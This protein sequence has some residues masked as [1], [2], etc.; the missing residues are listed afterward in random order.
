MATLAAQLKDTNS[1][2][3]FARGNNYA[4]ALE[5]ALKVRGACARGPRP[6]CCFG[7]HACSCAGRC[8]IAAASSQPSRPAPALH[9]HA[10]LTRLLAALHS[11]THLA[12][13]VAPPAASA[14]R[15]R[16][17]TARASWRAR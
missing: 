12:P 7:V 16:S 10:R 8:C 1:L 9:A 3:F 17:S 15:S 11:R 5:A 6:P 14:R 13:A 4:T 2:L